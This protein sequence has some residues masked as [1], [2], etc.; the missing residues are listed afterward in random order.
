MHSHRLRTRREGGGGIVTPVGSQVAGTSSKAASALG[1]SYLPLPSLPSRINSDAS[2]QS[3]LPHFVHFRYARISVHSQPGNLSGSLLRGTSSECQ[4]RGRGSLS[5]Q[6][7]QQT[8]MV[9][10][11]SGSCLRAGRST[12]S[13][14]GNWVCGAKASLHYSGAEPRWQ[15]LNSLGLG[16]TL[17]ANAR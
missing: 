8:R 10:K 3:T 15:I 2:T 11:P 17:P 9:L 1:S 14:A 13:A 6:P 4:Q 7:T 5:D 12:S 16:L